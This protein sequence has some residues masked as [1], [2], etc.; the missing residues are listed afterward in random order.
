VLLSLALAGG[1]MGCR[2]HSTPPPALGPPAGYPYA[3]VVPDCA[4]WDALALTL[5]LTPTPTDSEPVPPPFLR[6]SVYTSPSTVFGRAFQW[7]ESISEIGTASR[8][9]AGSFCLPAQ[10]GRIRFYALQADSTVAGTVD[11][12]FPDGSATRGRF[13]ARWRGAPALCG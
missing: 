11:L 6:V 1:L 5:Y 12:R 13:Q 4:P 7:K 10:A 9:L 3:M 2:P 8:C